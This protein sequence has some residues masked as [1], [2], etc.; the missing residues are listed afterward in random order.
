MASF[1]EAV[2]LGRHEVEGVT[3]ELVQGVADVSRVLAEGNLPIV[4]DPLAASLEILKPD[5][6][7]DA[8]MAK[9]NLGTSVRDAP[10]VIGLGP[11]FT[12]GSDC[13][14]V[15]ETHRGSGLGRVIAAGGAL[16]NTGIP[17][18]VMGYTTERV[19]RA[20]V[21]GIFETCL[22]VGH[23]VLAGDTVGLVAGRP[24]VSAIS[25]VL[26]G[27]L[28]NLSPVSAGLKVGDVDPRVDQAA[29][30]QVSDKALAVG[31]GVLEAVL[32]RYNFGTGVRNSEEEAVWPLA[33]P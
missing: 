22:D 20:P 3:A 8:I 4:V 33:I 26:R 15:V 23:T 2:R 30:D 25:G 28:P 6:L 10:L 31:G 7:V 17:G 27:I 12:A 19:L 14:R 11:G 21:E 9:R 32:E 29:C 1:S 16:P 24:V 13:H 18:M 5:I